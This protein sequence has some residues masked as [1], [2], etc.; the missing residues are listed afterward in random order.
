MNAM[1]NVYEIARSANAAQP[2]VLY[3]F[4]PWQ[5]LPSGSH[6]SLKTEIQLKMAGLAYIKDFT[7]QAQAPKG[8]LP[9]I[10]DGQEIVP[11]STFIRAHIE[12]KYGLDLDAGLDARQRAESWSIE[13]M[14]EDHL[15]WA[16]AWFRWIPAENFAA[17]PARF[18]DTAP[19]ELQDDLRNNALAKVTGN[20][21]AHGIGRHS[22]NEVAQL[23]IRS[24]ESFAMLLGGR[25]FLFGDAPTATDAT[26][27]GVLAALI[28]P[29]LDS[30][31][32]RRALAL[33]NVTDYVTRMMGRFYPP[34]AQPVAQPR[35]AAVKTETDA[36]AA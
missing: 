27:A 6:F 34:V 18:F 30:P 5:G 15:G 25:D 21:H 31:L 11:D 20:M 32:R 13:R 2:I 9:Y 12:R 29:D 16:M 19:A 10:R 26:A 17:G 4:G 23:G 7:G 3:S 35:D 28:V 1:P 8:K 14:L 33:D 22:M 36:A 24:L